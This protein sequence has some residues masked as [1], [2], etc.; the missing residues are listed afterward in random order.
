M[1][2]TESVP[3][4][5]EV[6]PRARHPIFPPLPDEIIPVEPKPKK[7]ILV[8]APKDFFIG[9]VFAAKKQ[10][11]P[12]TVTIGDKTYQVGGF[13]PFDR[14]ARPP[15]MDV[16]HARAIFTLLSFREKNKTDGKLLSDEE[17]DPLNIYFSMNDFCRCYA[18]SNGGR[19]SREILKIIGDLARSFIKITDSKTNKTLIYRLIERLEIEQKVIKRRDSSLAQTNQMEMW[20]HS[21]RLSPEFHGMLENILELRCLKLDVFNSIRSPIAQAI[22]LYIPSR[23][24][25][26]TESNPFEISLTTIL[27]QISITIPVQRSVRKKIFTQHEN[28]GRSILQQLD[29]LETRKGRFRV[30]LAVTVDGDDYKLQTWVEQDPVSLSLGQPKG[31]SKLLTAFLKG[32]RQR[33]EWARMLSRVAPLSD[34]EMELLVAAGVEFEKNRPF[35]EKAKAILGHCRF[36]EMLAEA[37]GDNLEGIKAKKSPAARLIYRLMVAIG[38]P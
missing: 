11:G 25:H 22:Y 26:H 32:G 2:A 14:D 31:D 36:D 33:E 13:D 9:P 4:T 28:E 1:P 29:G 21:C 37:K 8:A 6:N 19:Y 7:H 35:F 34:Y 15:A 12:R 5:L 27:R 3:K 38:T 23:A 17:Y 16:R 10:M 20:F 18:A 30:K 24:A